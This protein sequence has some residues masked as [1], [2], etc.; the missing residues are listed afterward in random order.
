MGGIVSHRLGRRLRVARA[1]GSLRLTPF[2]GGLRPF[3]APAPIFLTFVSQLLRRGLVRMP[4]V[5]PPLPATDTLIGLKSWG[6]GADGYLQLSM[7]RWRDRRGLLRCRSSVCASF[8]SRP[9]HSVNPPT[10]IPESAVARVRLAGRENT[11][12]PG[13]LSPTRL[14]LR[15]RHSSCSIGVRHVSSTGRMRVAGVQRGA[16]RSPTCARGAAFVV[17][18]CT[19]GWGALTGASFRRRL[20]LAATVA[21]ELAAR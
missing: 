18:A 16:C 20:M 9:S 4:Q 7:S 3:H 13:A 2:G 5:T 15:D 21:R 10:Y 1:D 8:C 11:A 17:Q 6:K 14:L 12:P 19:A